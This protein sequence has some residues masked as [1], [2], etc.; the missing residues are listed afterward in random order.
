MPIRRET[1][2]FLVPNTLAS[3]SSN[4]T[5]DRS[6]VPMYIN[7]QNVQI[8]EKKIISQQRTKGGYSIQYWG[9]ELPT[10]SAS[11][12]TGSGGI[13]AINILRDVYRHEQIQFKKI[14]LQR[15]RDLINDAQAS[16][17]DKS[18]STA[19]SGTISLIDNLF[20]NSISEIING[21]DSIIETIKNSVN[22]TTTSAKR[23]ELI[24]TL[25]SFA[26]SIDLYYQGEKYRGYFNDFQVTEDAGTPGFFNYSFSFIIL[27]RYGTR[28]N[29]MPWHRE[30]RD[31]T[32]T[33]I[34]ASVPLDGPKLD[35]LS[36]ETDISSTQAGI[37]GTRFLNSIINDDIQSGELDINN[38][39]INRFNKING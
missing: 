20:Q 1:I 26:V 4:D 23:I 14:L 32:G 12:N 25:A 15:T 37:A 39:G 3:L 13:E 8:Q 9:E 30:P 10:L 33:P 17:E 6:I 19:L 21:A 24:P 7:P 27:K 29:F 36:F 35:E 2:K 5:I 16:L 31:S 38:V 28:N 22:K 34:K 11:G 18:S